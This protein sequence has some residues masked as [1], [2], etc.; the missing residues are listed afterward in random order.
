MLRW[1]LQAA[2]PTAPSLDWLTPDERLRADSFRFEKRRNDWLNG[3]Y[4]AKRLVARHLRERTGLPVP[5]SFLEIGTEASGSPF[6]RLSPEAPPVA[7]VEPGRRLPVSLSISHSGGR[8]LAALVPSG[9]EGPA[10]AVGADVERVEPRLATF[11]RD[12]FT[13]GELASLPGDEGPERDLAVTAVWSAKEAVLKALGLGLT[14]DTRSVGID[15][16]AAASPAAPEGLAPGEPGWEPFGVSADGA[17]LSGSSV[18]GYLRSSAGFVLTL[19]VRL[20]SA[21]GADPVHALA[22]GAVP[23]RE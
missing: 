23:G 13:A 1:L 11:A 7:G 2:P 12:Y 18:H 9:G 15:L 5:L 22:A 4:A 3:R 10:A 21:A 17:L 19:A 16:S 8:A 6:A 20:P 14:V